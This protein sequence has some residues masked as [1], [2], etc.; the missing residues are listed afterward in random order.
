M[1]KSEMEL[2]QL[3]EIANKATDA[4]A[5]VVRKYYSNAARFQFREKDG[6]GPVTCA[7]VEAEQAVVSVIL[8]A[9]PSHSI[10]RE[11]T[12]W[13]NRDNALLPNQFIWVSDPIDGTSS[14]V[15]KD[16]CAFGILI[17]LVYNGKP[18]NGCIDQ[19]ILKLRWIGIK[20]KGTT[21][22]GQK[23]STLDC[24]D[25]DKA[26]VHLKVPNYNDDAK[27]AYDCLSNKVG[28]RLFNGNCIVFG[29]LASG[30]VDVVVDC[31]LDPYDFLALVPVVE[32]AGGIVTDWEGR[33][34]LWD[35]STRCRKVGLRLWLLLEKPY[36][37]VLFHIVYA[38]L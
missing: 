13:H 37:N 15:G 6:D 25:L 20:G 5:V 14:F 10:Y 31:A 32:G 4:A 19:P 23:V 12:G 22:N 30:F 24:C 28:K 17:A 35:A 34:L 7:D 2:N 8:E 27:R 18:I 38:I 26:R 9:F 16:N 36:I 1:A 3:S 21:I 29:E 11:E 33:E